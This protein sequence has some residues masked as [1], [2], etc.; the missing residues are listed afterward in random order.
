MLIPTTVL[1]NP[2][3]G[4]SFSLIETQAL[5]A[6]AGSVT[7]SAIPGTYE[8]L[9]ILWTARGTD[10]GNPDVY[11]RFNGD[12]GAN[13]DRELLSAVGASAAAAPSV[14]QTAIQTIGTMP[15]SAATAGRAAGG[16]IRIPSYART[17]FWKTAVGDFSDIRATGGG[18]ELAG[19]TGG[20]WR[21][22][23][24]ITSVTLLPS[25]GNFLA[26]RVF[27]LYGIA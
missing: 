26:G 19:M 1:T 14:A 16:A 5:G 3:G 11:L 18:N 8:H 7:F 9:M 20:I 25:A 4:G 27:S 22:T 13:Y 17:T 10:A 15:G 2:S 24:A 6:D 21:S 12:T 23:A